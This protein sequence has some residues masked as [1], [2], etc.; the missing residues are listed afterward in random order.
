MNKLAEYDLGK[1]ISKGGNHSEVYMATHIETA[2]QVAI[3]RIK[4]FDLHAAVRKEV[5]TEISLLQKLDHPNLI[6]YPEHFHQDNDLYIVMELASGGQMAQK[7][8]AVRKSGVRVEE[9]LLWGWL[10][11]VASALAY[12]H[13]RRVM[14][15]DV[16]P[17]H[18]FLGENGQAKLGD[19]GLSKVMSAKTQIAFSCVGTPFYMSPELVKSEGYAFGSDV[20]SLGCSIYE[21]A[22]G[23]PPFFRA[24][25]DFY[26][27]GDA[28]CSA[29]YP[30]LPAENWSKEFIEFFGHILE[31]DPR[32][33]PTAQKI[34][35]VTVCNRVGRIQEFEVLGTIGRGK[36]SEVHRALR[37]AGTESEVALKRVQIFEM[38]T[39]ARTDCITEVNLLKSLNHLTIVRYLDSF[40]DNNELVIVLELAPHGDLAGLCRT[41]KESD[42]SLTESQIWAIIFQVSDALN[43]MHKKR[44]MHRDLKPANIFLCSQGIVKLGDL[45]LGRYFSSNTYRAHSIVGTP[46]YMSPEVINHS[47]SGAGGYSF[48]SDIWSLGCVLYELAALQSPFACSR[49]N[50]YALGKQIC[51]G[52]YPALPDA[53]SR[54]VQKLCAEMIKVNPEN[55]PSAH[56]VFVA[57]DEQF[58]NNSPPLAEEAAGETSHKVQRVHAQLM[59]AAGVVRGT[60]EALGLAVP[61]LPSSAA[62]PWS[63]GS[64][65]YPSQQTS[66]ATVAGSAVAYARSGSFPESGSASARRAN[67]R[68]PPLA[69]TEV[70]PPAGLPP[71][72][73]REARGT[74][75]ERHPP[76]AGTSSVPK[77]PDRAPPYTVPTPPGV[78]PPQ[79]F[80][81]EDGSS[82]S[83][84]SQ[85]HVV[86]RRPVPAP[87]GSLSARG[88]SRDRQLHDSV[89]H[90]SRRTHTP[91]R[92]RQ[93]PAI[94]VSHLRFA[95]GGISEVW[96]AHPEAKGNLPPIKPRTPREA[97]REALY[98][99]SER[100][101]AGPTE[102]VGAA[103]S[104]AELADRGG[105]P[106]MPPSGRAPPVAASSGSGAAPGL[107]EEQ[108]P[109]PTKRPAPRAP[110]PP[111]VP[112]P[113]SAAVAS[114]AAGN[115][116]EATSLRFPG[117]TT[118]MRA[119]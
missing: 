23:Y 114:P 65:A 49:L 10:H 36:F 12:L 13:S 25:M 40:T 69:L 46:F 6:Q 98:A 91:E 51:S 58:T 47:G 73:A 53:A 113:P 79:P 3:K 76:A 11:D 74:L 111:A 24:D 68:P 34:L 38:D 50:Y 20:W 72:S 60:L 102:R 105:P 117:T 39:A 28:I 77:R 87:G 5:D 55:R 29:R 116:S 90:S 59:R 94:Q 30:A 33:R 99:A 54:N 103:A 89:S 82:A 52:E 93:Q 115:A 19:F 44:I 2:T 41:L 97:S 17:S 35:D 64:S 100:A 84:G 14:H 57:S 8:E 106:P 1:L 109:S 62:P 92:G 21:L 15:R 101:V 22:T 85:S 32:Q 107:L 118:S 88:S 48:K 7:V 71:H 27:L 56:A 66:V 80:P 4:L 16:K 67:E 81:R 75:S 26:A 70:S 108:V 63:A 119:H 83:S 37:K 18:I 78:P 42:R 104:A 110:A 95:T 96:K 45:G 86:R 9:K 31:V 61:A 112:I 43:Y